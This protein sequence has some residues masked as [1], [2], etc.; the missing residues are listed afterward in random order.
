MQGSVY[1]QSLPTQ[2]WAGP[3]PLQLPLR[4]L[5]SRRPLV[6]KPSAWLWTSSLSD[7]EHPSDWLRWC[8]A[9]QFDLEN[10]VWLSTFEVDPA[11]VF[12]IDGV[13]ALTRFM[14]R[15][16]VPDDAIVLRGAERVN[17]YSVDWTATT[18]AWG[19]DA[20]RVTQEG[21]WET[22]MGFPMST[23]SWDCE[24]T[25][26]VNPPT[27]RNLSHTIIKKEEVNA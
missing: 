11:V 19:A 26:W 4:P 24:S 25:A 20:L 10:R 1:R 18:L 5:S 9:E 13:D 6:G 22:R 14:S 15:A 27:I 7:G 17:D 12:T 2:T 3:C 23:Y 21:H 16:V 8:E